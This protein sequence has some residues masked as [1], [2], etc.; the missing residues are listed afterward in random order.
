MTDIALYPRILSEEQFDLK[1]LNEKQH[2]AFVKVVIEKKSIFL[3][4]SGGC[5]KSYLIKKINSCIENDINV[6]LT[7][8]TGISAM[9]LGGSTLHSFLGIRLGLESVATLHK[10]IMYSNVYL[11]RWRRL[12]LLI[13]D[14]ISMM[15]VELL[16]KI[17]ELARLLRRNER[18]FGG[19]QLLI[20]GDFLQLPPVKENQFCFESRVWNECI[21]ETVILTEVI[22]QQDKVFS[23]VL[24]KIRLNKIDNECM[25]VIGSR[26]I[27]YISDNGLIPTMLYAINAKVDVTNEKY[28]AALTGEEHAYKIKYK[29]SKNPRNKEQYENMAKLPFDLRLKVGAQVVHLVNANGLVNGS[30]GVVTEFIGGFPRVLFVNGMHELIHRHS[31]DIEEKDAL[32]L[33]YSQ[34][35]L[36]LA[37]AMSIHKS[38]GCT[39]DLVRVDLNKIFEYGQLYV[40]LSRC[41]SLEGLFIR[42]L[43]WNRHKVHPK[44]LEFYEQLNANA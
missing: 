19:I 10:K 36:K 13:I 31:L 7:S 14:E 22:R 6:G 37:W 24:N 40:A 28:Y 12:H 16:E 35:P 27:K 30:R 1:D 9:I 26:E 17:E 5:G 42:H 43:N 2:A 32:I 18:P 33:T 38:Q 21:Q 11:N 44:A 3:T 25:D 4:G 41:K 34:I 15:S 8:L 23:G 20:S 39:L 29:W